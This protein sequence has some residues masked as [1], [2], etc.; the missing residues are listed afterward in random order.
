MKFLS[1]SKNSC[2]I[3]G[4]TFIDNNISLSQ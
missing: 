4:F 1:K 3:I 2:E